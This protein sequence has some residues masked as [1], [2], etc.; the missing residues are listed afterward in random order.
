MASG[1]E[2]LAMS[3]SE[4]CAAAGGD[5]PILALK[6]R[7]HS[8]CGQP[9]FKQRLLLADG[10]ILADDAAIDTWTFHFESGHASWGAI[11]VELLHSA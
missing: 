8:L 3:R 4:L 10:T 6:Q 1:E 9:R 2:V 7:L 5:R 11:F